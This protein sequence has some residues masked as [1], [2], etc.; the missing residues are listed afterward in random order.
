MADL[1]YICG[2]N[3]LN[4]TEVVKLEYKERRLLSMHLSKGSLKMPYCIPTARFRYV[5]WRSN[6]QIWIIELKGPK[7]CPNVLRK[8]CSL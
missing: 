2:E 1:G 5:Q 3:W 7:L 4:W 6:F 8:R